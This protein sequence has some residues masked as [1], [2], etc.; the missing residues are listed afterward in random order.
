M[1]LSAGFTWVYM[2]R[3]HMLA[4]RSGDANPSGRVS[5]GAPWFIDG[6]ADAGIRFRHVRGEN[7]RFWFPEIIAGGCGLFDY[8]NDGR[9]DAFFVQGGELDPNLPDS[10]RSTL[11]RNLG[12]GKFMN[13]TEA[14][15]IR[16]LNYGMGCAIGDIDN[17]GDLDLY[18]TAIGGNTL[19]QNRGDGTFEDITERAGVRCGRWSTSAV[20]ADY[21]GDGL[22][23]LYVVNYVSWSPRNELHCRDSAGRREYCNPSNYNAPAVDALY[24]NLGGGRFE[25][26]T[27]HSG[28]M[29]AFGNG[30]GVCHGDFNRDGRPDFYVANDGMPNQ[31]WINLGDGRFEDQALLA[32]CAL[33]SRGSAEAGMGVQAVDIDDNG[34]LDIF[35]THLRGETNRL[36]LNVGGIFED[37]TSASGLGAS[38]LKYTGWGVGFHDFD[39]D[40]QLDLF[41]GNG[42]VTRPEQCDDEQDMYA[43][44]KSLYRGIGGGRFELASPPGGTSSPLL[45]SSRAVA[46]GDVDNDGDI[47]I[48]IL[49]SDRSPRLL[50]NVAGERGNWV[51]FRI[52]EKYGRDAVGATLA[53]EAAGVVR[54]R[55][56]QSGYSFAAANDLR[57]HVG[58]GEAERVD[59]VEI[60]WPDGSKSTH[61]PFSAGRQHMI[62]QSDHAIS[63]HGSHAPSLN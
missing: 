35:L 2:T 53:V 15:G 43:E 36:Y 23:D 58:L 26:V 33:D 34:D 25:D 51:M 5:V 22:L 57:V 4:R 7:Q 50:L 37:W 46:F 52:L 9:L 49:E 28:I 41:I 3:P 40:G 14:A 1:A 59:R 8:D 39:H 61:G 44:P 17:D 62:R 10:S 31:L 16:H 13:V 63:A 56:V 32:G 19:Y 47:D 27:Q 29:L 45:G 18:V 55:Q 21:D 30:L 48:L 42:A 12:D 24:H 6:T 20:F 60:S 11:Y 54:R 38:S